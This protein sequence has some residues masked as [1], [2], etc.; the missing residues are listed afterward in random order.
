[1]IKDRPLCIFFPEVTPYR[2]DFDE[3]ECMYFM[4]K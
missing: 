4:T 2:M 3:T 1:M